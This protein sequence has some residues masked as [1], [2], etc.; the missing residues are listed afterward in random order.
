MQV[1]LPGTENL[2][3]AELAELLNEKKKI[4]G[5]ATRVNHITQYLYFNT[6]GEK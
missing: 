1:K 6:Q 5:G 4:E 2:T 3:V